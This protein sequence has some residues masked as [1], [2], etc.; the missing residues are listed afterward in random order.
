MSRGTTVF[1]ISTGTANP[2][3]AEACDGL[4][5]AV[6]MPIS[7]PA[8]SSSGPPEFPGL[9][10]ASVWITPRMLSPSSVEIVRP[11]PL[12]TPVVSVWSRP[13]GLPIANTLCP[14]SRSDAVPSARGSSFSEGAPRSFRTATSTLGS[15]PTRSAAYVESSANVTR[16]CCPERTTCAFVTT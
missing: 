3:P 8:L 11:K 10:A 4:M 13:K 16:N 14:T 2:M 6:F 5:M 9:M 7:R 1:T 15:A 12:T